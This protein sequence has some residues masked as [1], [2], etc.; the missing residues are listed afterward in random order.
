L[1]LWQGGA[2]SG[3]RRNG[4]HESAPDRASSGPSGGA[5][6]IIS[7]QN[8]SQTIQTLKNY[9]DPQRREPASK[10]L[11]PIPNVPAPSRVPVGA[12]L[13][14]GAKVVSPKFSPGRGSRCVQGTRG[15]WVLLPVAACLTWLGPSRACGV[16]VGQLDDFEAGNVLNWGNGGPAP[17]PQNLADGGPL[18]AGDNFLRVTSDGS[19]AAG[20][21]T[22]FNR[23]QW[24]GAAGGV[25]NY[26]AAGI[27]TIE[28]DLK[29]LGTA[30]LTIRLAFRTDTGQ[31][32]PGYVSTT[33]FSLA[34][35]SNWQHATF[36]LSD[37]TPA[38][39][40]PGSL[41]S[42]LSNPAE[43]RILHSARPDTVLRDNITGTLGIDN[44]RAVPE[45]AS[46]GLV[47]LGLGAIALRRRIRR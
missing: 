15:K 28:M 19:G 14:H 12:P 10:Q 18:G 7:W 29:N 35:G 9:H 38:I 45:P 41:N 46:A 20:K 33:G 13:D 11:E 6:F 23:V 2:S 1:A 4:K 39:G 24:A 27:T 47:A 8:H 25:D 36:L 44:V 17:D 21:L 42:V 40:S 22:I 30:A 5:G 32:D 16:T 37:M 31:F 3:E 26:L 34:V 43:M